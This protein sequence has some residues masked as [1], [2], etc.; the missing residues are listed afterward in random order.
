MIRFRV[1]DCINNVRG[2]PPALFILR[3]Q[4]L[5]DIA[6]L[7]YQSELFGLSIAWEMTAKPT[8]YAFFRD[9][10]L[11]VISLFFGRLFPTLHVTPKDLAGKVAVVTGA[12]SGIGFQ[13][14]LDLIKQ[15]ATVYLACRSQSKAEQAI[16][17]ITKQVP[18]SDR[19]L[20]S[21]VL[22]TSSLISVKDAIEGLK[23]DVPLIDI[24]VHNAGIGTGSTT[25]VSFTQ[26]RL[27]VVYATNFLGSFLM[28][29]LLESQLADDAH[30]VLTTSTGQYAGRFSSN[31]ALQPVYDRV[32]KGFHCPSASPDSATRDSSLY[33]NTKS[34]Q[35]CFAKLLRDR[36]KRT[37]AAQGTNDRRCVNAFSPGFTFT[38]IFE[39]VAKRPF[40]E[41][42][43]FWLLRMTASWIGIHVS[44]GAATGVWLSTTDDEVVMSKGSG[45][46]YWERM[47]RRVSTADMIESEK[48]EMLWVRWEKDAGVEWR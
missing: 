28:T 6:A 5:T 4:L 2:C 46:G 14:T 18:G 17:E 21:L 45:G 8:R 23:R 26:E 41:D 29:H 42:P 24:L 37:A 39:K 13:I 47:S 9:S 36:W 12:N 38:P 19:R 43:S 31:F 34:M 48:L 1:P 40:R 33:T 3:L 25:D 11:G 20:R 10:F 15:G 35:C 22:D 7:H 32:E 44:Q 30:V 16:S 27:P